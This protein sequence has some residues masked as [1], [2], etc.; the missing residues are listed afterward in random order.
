MQEKVTLTT[1]LLPWLTAFSSWR[2]LSRWPRSRMAQGE[3]ASRRYLRRAQRLDIMCDIKSQLVSGCPFALSTWQP[4]LHSCRSNAPSQVALSP[5]PVET[6]GQLLAPVRT[7]F[8]P[9]GMQAPP[10]IRRAPGAHPV[11]S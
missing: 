2:R 3:S 9:H 7:S 10:G 5:L 6:T 4:L 11:S 8:T 1:A